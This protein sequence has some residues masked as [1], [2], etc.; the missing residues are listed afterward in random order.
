M[1]K[2]VNSRKNNRR[3]AG[4][5]L[6][7]AAGVIFTAVYFFLMTTS[8]LVQSIRPHES[9]ENILSAANSFFHKVSV[10]HSRFDR[11]ISSGID[12]NLLKYAQY[13]N[14]K[15]RG[16]PDLAPGYW[17]IRW[18]P[19]D[20]DRG[21]ADRR[22]PYLET[23]YDFNGGLIGFTDNTGETGG[24]N[25][26][27]NIS[28]EDAL[29]EAKY[30]LG[31]YGIK[32]DSLAVTDRE[33]SRKGNHTQYKFVLENKS[34]K[35]PGLLYQYTVELSGNRVANYQLNRV[36]DAKTTRVSGDH[37]DSNP[38]YIVWV[39]TWFIIFIFIVVRFMQK[40]RRDELEFARALR[41]G[42][43]MGLLMIISTAA[44]GWYGGHWPELLL[45]SGLSALFILLGMLLLLPVA[46]SQ[47]RASWPEK[48]IVSDLLFQGKFLIRETGAALLRSFFLV[49]L[50][51]LVTGALVRAAGA[52]NLCFIS[53]PDRQF[54][55]FQNL[56]QAA[57][58]FLGDILLCVFIGLSILFFWP[59][60]LKE[61]L[62]HKSVLLLLLTL[63]LLLSGLP[64]TFFYP[65]LSSALLALPIAFIF[66]LIAYRYD[67]LTILFSFLGTKILL[68]LALAFLY[69]GS[70]PGL[71]G[72]AVVI[73]AIFFLLVGIY[74]VFRPQSA[75]DYENYVPEYVNRIS[76]RER[77]L[78]E[79]EI[80][81]SVQMRFLPQ[82]L[83]DFPSLEIVSL[84]QPAMEVGGDYYDF[85]QISERYMSVLIGDVSGKGVSAAF[86][87]TMVKGIIKTLS[88]KVM[89][90]ASLLAE[91]NEIFCENAPRDVFITI[92]YGIFDLEE[93]TLTF[94]SAG[95]N[96]LIVWKKKTGA[97]QSVNPRG[98]ALGLEKGPQ[99]R[100]IIEDAVIP[101]EEDDIYVF[102]TDGVTEAM[103]TKQEIFGE[104]R[105][106]D[107]IRRNANLPPRILQKKIIE[108]VSDFSGKEPQHDDFTMV[109]IK[110]KDPGRKK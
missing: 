12:N 19:S 88:R 87:M 1:E 21:S 30:F 25:S 70:L 32:T 5:I 90:P 59:A 72:M 102:Y 76:E 99:Y 66:A 89:K 80:A 84:C 103:N 24:K 38:A 73:I 92:I 45:G 82:K 78:R 56:P 47:N 49:G 22:N 6:L 4:L 3:N 28:E 27:D 15:N 14:E 94:A 97:T 18:I 34:K 77:F 41:T 8:P 62:R 26:D 36:L 83:P 67:L 50:I 54:T 79:L 39:V 98:I 29:F 93:R 52:F 91:A 74:L 13:Y 31:E 7:A 105:L 109:V 68:D 58:I 42:I 37:E 17:S 35:Y 110:V 16:Y 20:R 2:I 23:R 107:T 33:I 106:C 75:E 71:V 11:I 60:Y 44:G 10:N 81:R 51:L 9:T 43:A 53:F 57:G 101:I 48:L 40:L 108:A 69:P 104:E 65:Q 63:S 95:H 96:P 100:A 55:V 61:K 46:D 85:V 86:Y 64:F